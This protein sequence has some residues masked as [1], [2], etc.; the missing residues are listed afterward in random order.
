MPLR[1]SRKAAGES[2]LCGLSS[3]GG[4]RLSHGS[5][6]LLARCGLHSSLMTADV[7]RSEGTVQTTQ[8]A[9]LLTTSQGDTKILGSWSHS[10][11]MCAVASPQLCSITT[12]G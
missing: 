11:F 1:E 9:L 4:R 10:L 7:Q 3:A 6:G 12:D 5:P 8:I 2:G